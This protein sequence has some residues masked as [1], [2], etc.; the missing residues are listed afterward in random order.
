MHLKMKDASPN[1][2]NLMDVGVGIMSG[3]LSGIAVSCFF[4]WKIIIFFE[5]QEIL[6]G[7]ILLYLNRD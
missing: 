4:Q 3:G 6:N 2:S 5:E 1:Q 7:S